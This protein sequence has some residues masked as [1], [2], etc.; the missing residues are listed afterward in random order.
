MVAISL[1]V[2]VGLW[3]GVD[4]ASAASSPPA[5][6]GETAAADSEA[7][8]CFS[9]STCIGLFTRADRFVALSAHNATNTNVFSPVSQP[10]VIVLVGGG[11]LALGLLTLLRLRETIFGNDSGED[12]EPWKPVTDA[13]RVEQLLVAND[14][15]M[16]QSRI[17]EETDW[18]KAKVSRLLS[19]MAEEGTIRKDKDGRENII[20]LQRQ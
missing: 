13:D 12:R 17:V 6:S 2:V 20:I 3:S 9:M 11:V 1:V 18:S 19:R 4:V 15:Y 8:G 5:I 14:G 7:A 16:K 10:S